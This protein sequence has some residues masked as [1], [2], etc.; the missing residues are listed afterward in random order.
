MIT[1][2]YLSKFGYAIDFGESVFIVD[3]TEGRLPSQYLKGSKQCYFVVSDFTNDHFVDSI[4]AYRKPIISP[5]DMLIDNELFIVSAGDVLHFGNVKVMTIGHKDNGLGFI[6]VKDGQAVFHTGSF[7]SHSKRKNP[8]NLQMLE[9]LDRFRFLTLS[10]KQLVKPK[11]IITQVNPLAGQE[12]DEDAKFIVESLRPRKVFPS[13]FGNYIADIARFSEWVKERG[14]TFYG[15]K[16]E[17][18]KYRIEE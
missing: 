13:N 4:K 17:N 10:I 7:S 11:L 2:E 16:Q 9:A 12:Y 18:K 6:F 14:I 5:K 1:I 8:S 15:P 3:Y